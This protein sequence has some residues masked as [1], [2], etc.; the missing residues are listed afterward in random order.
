MTVVQTLEMKLLRFS[1]S[2]SGSGNS[3]TYGCV[4][5]KLVSNRSARK[6]MGG[7]KKK[8]RANRLCLLYSD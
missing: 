1:T 7:G 6:A 5:M 8:G 4:S 3:N 2:F